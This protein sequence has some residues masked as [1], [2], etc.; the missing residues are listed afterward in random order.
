MLTAN[1]GHAASHH[2]KH[3]SKTRIISVTGSKSSVTC[4]VWAFMRHARG[5][6]PRC[7]QSLCSKIINLKPFCHADA[8]VFSSFFTA[9]STAIPPHHS[10]PIS[11]PQSWPSSRFYPAPTIVSNSLPPTAPSSTTH[12]PSC[13]TAPRHPF[14]RAPVARAN[15]TASC[16][17]LQTPT[18]LRVNGTP[19]A[20]SA[21]Q[22][23]CARSYPAN[24][25]LAC[26]ATG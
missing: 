14:H 25:D 23:Q 7:H 17:S 3:I 6:I 11:P 1:N 10:S 12:P 9:L 16:R 24:G 8:T 26:R 2:R 15:P 22:N 18:N 21:P 5:L 13:L 19:E 4:A 20:A